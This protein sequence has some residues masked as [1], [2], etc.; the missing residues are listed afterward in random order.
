M[1]SF[2][3][4]VGEAAAPGRVQRSQFY[5][6]VLGQDIHAP[7]GVEWDLAR[8]S[9]K[10]VLAFR[11]ELLPTPAARAFEV[12]TGAIWQTYHTPMELARLLQKAL[13]RELMDG[14]EHYGVSPEE[15]LKLKAWLGEIKEKVKEGKGEKRPDKRR[16]AGGGGVILPRQK[17]N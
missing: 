6:L 13:A 10:R 2:N 16:G 17:S 15:W 5:G 4:P 3:T 8:R 7:M 9:G 1:A 12:Q 14:A 11:K